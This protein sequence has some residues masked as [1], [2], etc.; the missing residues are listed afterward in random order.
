MKKYLLVLLIFLAGCQLA[1]KYPELPE[2]EKVPALPALYKQRP[3]AF[4]KAVIDLP[5]GQTYIAYPYWRWSFDNVDIGVFGACNTTAKNRF[6]NSTA[7]WAEGEKKF[8]SW[9]DEA[10]EFFNTPL[11]EK[12]YDIVDVFTTTFKRNREKRRA[13]LLI[14][15]RIKDIKSNQCNLF[16]SVLMQSESLIGGDAYVEVEWEVY[17]TLADK[18]I[19]TFTTAGIGVVSKPTE[20]GNELILLRAL[21]DAARRLGNEADFYRLVTQQG[22]LKDLMAAESKQKS[23]VLEM[24]QKQNFRPLDENYFLI[25]RATVTIGE[26]ASGFYITRE[27]HILTTAEAVGSARSVSVEDSYGTRFEAKV[28]RTNFRLNVALLKAVTNKTY[29]LPIAE[30]QLLKPLMTVFVIGNPEGGQARASV[31]RGHISN[32]RYKKKTGEEFIQASVTTTAGYAGAPL[33]DEFG[34]VLGLHDGRNS[35]ETAF[36]YFIPIHEALRALNIKFSEKPLN[37]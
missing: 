4:E 21:S 25:K 26:D 9:Q 5:R 37:Y 33:L 23:V 12:G 2:V 22:T 13:E 35:E 15:A 18:V 31:T 36:S 11:K 3:I 30:E 17:D 8:G 19:A 24:Q 34:N 7:D 14:S 28:L 27:G 10:A 1:M 6:G 29:L 20:K 16:N 32:L